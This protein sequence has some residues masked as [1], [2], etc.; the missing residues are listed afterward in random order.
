MGLACSW[1]A[2]GIVALVFLPLRKLLSGGD[3]SKEG[4]VFYV[5]SAVLTVLALILLRLYR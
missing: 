3:E 4:H 5:F 1:I 2:N